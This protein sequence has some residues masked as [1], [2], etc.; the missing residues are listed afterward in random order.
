MLSEKLYNKG[1]SA[2][3]LISYIYYKKY[4]KN[5]NDQTLLSIMFNFFRI[6]NS[7][8]DEKILISIILDLYFFRCTYN[9]ENIDFL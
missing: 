3:H 8:R 7:I 5:T 4:K 9:L 1:V 6:K 2:N